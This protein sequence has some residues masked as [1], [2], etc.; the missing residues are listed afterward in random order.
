[1]RWLVVLDPIAGLVAKTDTS[2]AIIDKARSMGLE[3]DTAA[4]EDLFFHVVASINAQDK[5]GLKVVRPLDDYDLILMRKEPPYDLPFHYATQLLSLTATPVINRPSSLRDFNEKLMVLP[6][7]EY[8]PPTLVSSNTRQL[9]DFISTYDRAV[10]KALDSFQGKSVTRVAPDDHDLIEKCTENGSQPVMVQ[11]FLAAVYEGDKRV[12][13]AGERVLG[14]VQRRP[15]NG[16]HANFAN[17]D[18]LPAALTKQ[19]Q[20][21]IEIL[22]P[23][24]VSHGIYFSGLDFIGEQLTEINITCPTG[25][26]QISAL[27]GKDIAAEVVEYFLGLISEWTGR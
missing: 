22:G 21:I 7:S 20:R 27:D 10:L 14:A 12:M 1:M 13:M 9:L 18:A 5:G 26:V 6:F 17:S 25:I 15:K 24:L 3:V 4:I 8:M 2:L 11:Q 23:W 16:Y 19:E